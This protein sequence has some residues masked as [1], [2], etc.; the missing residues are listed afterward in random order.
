MSELSIGKVAKKSGVSVETIRF[1]ERKGLIDEPPRLKSG[2]RRYDEE[3]VKRLRFIQQA[4]TL[5]FSLREIG[6]LL[7]LRTRPG[8]TNREIR[9]MAQAKLVNIEEKIKMLRRMQRTLKNLVNKCPGQGSTS[10]C[11]I[12]EAMDRLQ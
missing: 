6:D 10:H 9:Q 5:G 12:L 3:S 4:K 11:P 1:Y 2:Y 7:S 8:A